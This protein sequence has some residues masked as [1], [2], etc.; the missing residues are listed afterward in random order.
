MISPQFKAQAAQK[1]QLARPDFYIAFAFTPDEIIFQ[2]A[3][4]RNVLH[5]RFKY[6]KIHGNWQHQ[7]IAP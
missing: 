3:R 1:G 2:Q 6:T 4:A 7:R 5:D